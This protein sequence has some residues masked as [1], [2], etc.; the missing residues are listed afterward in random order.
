MRTGMETIRKAVEN[1]LLGESLASIQ[2]SYVMLELDAAEQ[3]ELASR[4]ASLEAGR[5]QR[6]RRDATEFIADVCR[7]LGDVHAQDTRAAQALKDWLR[8]SKDYAA[9]D[10]LLSNFVFPERDVLLAEAKRLFP[11]TLTA[12]WDE[13]RD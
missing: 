3:H 5:K 2:Q 6:L 13:N 9:F 12:H 11:G 4:L 1:V 7:K 10:A 8:R